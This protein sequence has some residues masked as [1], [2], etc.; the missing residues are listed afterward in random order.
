MSKDIPIK[1]NIDDSKPNLKKAMA[2]NPARAKEV[3]ATFVEMM[4]HAFRDG[5]ADLPEQFHPDLTFKGLIHDIL[6]GV[7]DLKNIDP[8]YYKDLG[9]AVHPFGLFSYQLPDLSS[10]H[11]NSYYDWQRH[12]DWKEG[13]DLPAIQSILRKLLYYARYIEIDKLGE[14]MF[15]KDMDLYLVERDPSPAIAAHPAIQY[16]R[17]VFGERFAGKF[18]DTHGLFDC[19]TMKRRQ[20]PD[21]C[22]ACT[23]GNLR[24][25]PGNVIGCERCGAGYKI[26]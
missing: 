24:E 10:I 5:W 8:V 3:I 22:P 21:S 6:H 20:R 25:F 16:Q 13:R 9:V 26:D 19:G 7:L 2:E 4:E 11:G 1:I 18:I 17:R 23:I 14:A 15:R 12:F